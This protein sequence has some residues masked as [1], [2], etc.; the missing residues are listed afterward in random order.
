MMDYILVILTAICVISLILI[1]TYYLK[2]KQ[3]SNQ[4]YNPQSLP[5]ASIQ[6]QQQP[7]E[8]T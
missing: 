1:V 6:K 7:Q 2:Q 5:I 8:L 3:S 4:N